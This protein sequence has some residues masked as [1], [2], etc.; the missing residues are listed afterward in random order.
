[1]QRANADD[2]MKEC[3]FHGLKT[4]QWRKLLKRYYLSYNDGMV[5]S[6]GGR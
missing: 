6:G 3:E 1:M 5:S 2:G 4:T